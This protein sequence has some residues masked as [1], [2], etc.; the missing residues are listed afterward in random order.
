LGTDGRAVFIHAQ[1]KGVP[2]GQAVRAA[3]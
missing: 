2:T 3:L 1:S